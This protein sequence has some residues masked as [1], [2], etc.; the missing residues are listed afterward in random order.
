M[1]PIDALYDPKATTIPVIRYLVAVADHRHF[2][3]AAAACAVSQPTLSAQISQWERRLGQQVFE[4]TSSGV[5]LTA[6]GAS[7]VAAARRALAEI[8][9]LEI[10]ATSAT[11]PFFGPLRVGIIPTLGP[12]LLPLVGSAIAARWPDLDWRVSEC[13]TA[14]L[15]ERLDR[16]RLD[17]LIL[18]GVAG[19]R[20]QREV[21]PLFDEPF[22]AALPRAHRLA[23]SEHITPADLGG[24]HLLLLEDGHCLR[25]QAL[26]I[27]GSLQPHRARG[28]YLATSLETLRQFVA[29]GHGVTVLPALAVHATRTDERLVIRPFAGPPA[30]RSIALVWRKGDVRAAGYRQFGQLIATTIRQQ[31]VPWMTDGKSETGRAKRR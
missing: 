9:A 31:R 8:Q 20:P 3:R 16:H 5:R 1:L 4:R 26:A 27:C 2:G 28:D 29:L 22:L 25:D 21:E 23:A 15:L 14:D 18:A 10:A 17:V 6:V 19:L 12:Y 30:S 11:P 7:V 13:Q 24:D